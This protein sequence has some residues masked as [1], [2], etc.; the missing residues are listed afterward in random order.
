[1]ND[2]LALSQV[3]WCFN[4]KLETTSEFNHEDATLSQPFAHMVY[5]TLKDSS[6]EACQRLIAACKHFL[7]DH[8]GTIHFSA[9]SLA[10]MPAKIPS[11]SSRSRSSN[12]KRGT[13]IF[14]SSVL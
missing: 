2:R 8:D 5:F 10:L 9:G 1:M 14:V 7:S 4:L 12:W 11:S 3:S 13:T 6:D